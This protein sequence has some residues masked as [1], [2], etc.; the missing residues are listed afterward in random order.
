MI[1]LQSNI[2]KVSVLSHL[3]LPGIWIIKDQIEYRDN[4]DKGL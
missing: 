1:N 2:S 3:K 4:G